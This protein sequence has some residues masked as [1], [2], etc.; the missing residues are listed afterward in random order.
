[1][2]GEQPAPIRPEGPPKPVRLPSAP[3]IASATIMQGARCV[4]IDHRGV[5]YRLQET[6]FGKLILTK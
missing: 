4:E 1:M 2:S 6:Q 3:P 5:I